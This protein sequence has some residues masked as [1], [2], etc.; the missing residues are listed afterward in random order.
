M[1]VRQ[2]KIAA[3]IQR[4]VSQVLARDVADPRI[5]G[6][7]TITR[8]HVTPDLREARVFVSV[9]GQKGPAATVL[10]GIRSA[11]RHIQSEVG[12][13]LT[14][15]MVPRLS[16]ELDE[17]LKKEAEILRQIDSL[18]REFRPVKPEGPQPG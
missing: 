15:R 2:Q 6:L 4:L 1:T 10:A 9:L 11:G 16:F 3:Q 7:V 17:S 14:L 8:V 13:G 18:S 5:G 12:H